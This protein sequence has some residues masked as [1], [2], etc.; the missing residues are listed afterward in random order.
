MEG[1]TVAHRK[2]QESHVRP[3]L[4][5]RRHRQCNSSARGVNEDVIDWHSRTAYAMLTTATK[6]RL[7][8]DYGIEPVDAG[9]VNK[10]YPEIGQAMPLL[11]K[12]R[13]DLDEEEVAR[14]FQHGRELDMPEDT[15]CLQPI[16]D[17][18]ELLD[19][20]CSRNEAN[21]WKDWVKGQR[22]KSASKAKA[23]DAFREIVKAVHPAAVTACKASSKRAAKAKAKPAPKYSAAKRKHNIDRLENGDFELLA[24]FAP[25]TVRIGVENAGTCLRMI[26]NSK[27]IGSVSWHLRGRAV[28]L[29]E[30]LEKSWDVSEALD[31]F[32]CP[33]RWLFEV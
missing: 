25:P 19:H 28:A 8:S 26:R 7:L 2:P 1:H 30:V 27:R 17:D 21:S 33:H 16:L 5:Q 11:T 4:R 32:P 18:E 14:C 24:L 12:L 29:K 22:S 15:S 31:Q 3:E 6:T 20:V 9:K 13:P 10:E 23:H